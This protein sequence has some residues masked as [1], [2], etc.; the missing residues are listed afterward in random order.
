VLIVATAAAADVAEALD[1]AWRAFRKAAGDD[2]AGWDMARGFP[3]SSGQL[4]SLL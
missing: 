4:V 2:A 1:L 3:W